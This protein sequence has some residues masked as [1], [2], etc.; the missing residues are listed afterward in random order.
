MHIPWP[1]TDYWHVL[2]LDARRAVHDGLLANDSISFHTR[3][4]R[5]NFMRSAEDVVGATCD[6][7]A[8]RSA[9]RDARWS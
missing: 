2:P 9:T 4:W 8:T 7:A 3:R 5:R 6:Y 1:Q